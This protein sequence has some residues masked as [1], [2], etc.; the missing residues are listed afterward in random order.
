[1]S[2]R[3]P[4]RPQIIAFPVSAPTQ[5]KKYKLVQNIY[6]PKV[7]VYFSDF[8]G[9]KTSEI[10]TMFEGANTFSHHTSLHIHM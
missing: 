3:K 2:I 4:L 7:T 6:N 1:M 10:E 5:A 8:K 9:D